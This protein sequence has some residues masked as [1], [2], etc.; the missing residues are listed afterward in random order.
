MDIAFYK[1][2]LLDEQKALASDENET[3]QATE[4]VKLDQ[5]KVG[6]LSRM[7]ALQTQAM[8]LETK[9]R[10]E[11]E[12]AKIKSALTRIENNDYGY[13]WHCDEEISQ[14]RLAINPATTL[15][16]DCANQREN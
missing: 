6:R 2:L 15:C 8:S 1:Q 11:L 14:K 3:Q 12:L 4:I 9:R 13:C 10:R 7:D 16:F 5:S